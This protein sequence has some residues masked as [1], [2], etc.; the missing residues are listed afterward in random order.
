MA[1]IC[2]LHHFI[3]LMIILGNDGLAK[4]AG[5]F[6][7]LRFKLNQDSIQ[8]EEEVFNDNDDLKTRC[9][10]ASTMVEFGSCSLDHTRP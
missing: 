3:P 2:A 7:S 1:T 8:V 4:V 9:P 10:F 5:L 6:L